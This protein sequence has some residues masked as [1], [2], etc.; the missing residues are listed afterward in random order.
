MIGRD[1]IFG[2]HIGLEITIAATISPGSVFWGQIGPQLGEQII[3]ALH[4]LIDIG[5]TSTLV[6]LG[7]ILTS[8]NDLNVNKIESINQ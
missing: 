1:E 2:T 7:M 4:P 5:W 6:G 8:L 3:E